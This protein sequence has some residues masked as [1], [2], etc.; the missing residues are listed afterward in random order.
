M[1][2]LA[3]VLSLASGSPEVLRTLVHIER[4]W[5]GMSMPARL[6]MSVSSKTH[7]DLSSGT[8]ETK[9][10]GFPEFHRL[11]LNAATA[12][13]QMQGKIKGSSNAPHSDC[14]AS[15]DGQ[16][17]AAEYISAPQQARERHILRIQVDL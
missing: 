4:R 9:P 7:L 16:N 1:R 11:A 6:V 10:A 3:V 2:N 13:L 17:S 5:I 14:Q 8:E 15:E 12:K